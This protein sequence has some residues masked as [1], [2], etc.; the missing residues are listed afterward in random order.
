MFGEVIKHVDSHNILLALKN[1]YRKQNK[2]Y[3]DKIW[4]NTKKEYSWESE[5]ERVKSNILIDE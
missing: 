2:I 1:F 3:I 5:F 4:L